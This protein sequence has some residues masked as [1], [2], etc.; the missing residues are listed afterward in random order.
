MRMRLALARSVRATS[1]SVGDIVG[2]CRLSAVGCRLSAIGCRLSAVRK[3][4]AI[5]AEGAK[6][7]RDPVSELGSRRRA[8]KSGEQIPP[9]ARDDRTLPEADG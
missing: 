3:P 9:C 7:P 6:R 2:G 5:H 8:T 1:V 4:E